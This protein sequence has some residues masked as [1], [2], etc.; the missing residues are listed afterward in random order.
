MEE[1][2]E[3]KAV[4]QKNRERE[5]MRMAE[6]Q[7]AAAQAKS[8]ALPGVVSKLKEAQREL[9]DSAAQRKRQAMQSR[10]RGR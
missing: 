4:V 2:E 8:D 10:D 7:A 9:K 5:N 3:G 6:K 1:D